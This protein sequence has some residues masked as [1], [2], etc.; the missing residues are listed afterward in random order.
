[1]ADVPEQQGRFVVVTGGSSGIGLQVAAMFAG[2][3]ADVLIGC[4]D[5]ARAEAAVRH[6]R[7]GRPA[8]TVA[9]A[10]LDLAD[11]DSVADFAA[12]V[13]GGRDRVDVLV[14]NAGVMW[15]PLWRTAQ[16]HELQFGVNHLGHFALTGLL[17]PLL[18]RSEHPRVAVATS[19]AQVEGT[20]AFADLDWRTRPYSR[21]AAYGQ[22]KLATMLFALE[23]D[24]RS[25]AA[26]SGLTVT[27]SHPGWTSTG[28]TR[29]SPAVLRRLSPVIGMRPEKG[30][31]TAMRAAAD[32][33]AESG[34]YW[35]PRHLEL[36]GRP[37]R[38]R[39]I[40]RARDRRVAARLWAESSRMSGI[41]YRHVR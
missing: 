7:E 35:G 31:L 36:K 20:I 39:I 8:G 2:K 38:A 21:R 32:P 33:A 17:M 29:H 12:E 6:I 37:A 28:L 14:N 15:C 4:R 22:S 27:A 5:L 10:R 11:L 3:G 13:G 23:L 34:T 19:L 26:G 24:R 9:A 30:A 41:E 25:R 16:G 1:L 18:L 40:E